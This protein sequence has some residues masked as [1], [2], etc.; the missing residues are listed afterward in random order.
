MLWLYKKPA[1]HKIF[2]CNK[3]LDKKKDNVKLF[4]LEN[5]ASLFSFFYG[6]LSE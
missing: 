2:F 4:R 5:G 1:K 6:G 3:V